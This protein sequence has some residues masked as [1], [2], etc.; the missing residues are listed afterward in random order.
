[1]HA[2]SCLLLTAKEP[3][4]WSVALEFFELKERASEILQGHR[5]WWIGLERI[6]IEEREEKEEASLL[7][8]AIRSLRILIL[9]AL[10][11][12]EKALVS[13]W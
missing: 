9:S 1:M 8:Y 12:F 5:S 7:I 11:V 13:V 4:W 10:S 3:F 6:N 2:L